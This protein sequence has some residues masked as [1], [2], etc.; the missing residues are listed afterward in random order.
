MTTHQIWSC[1]VPTLFANF[2]KFY[3]YFTFALNFR[4]NRQICGKL[5]QEQKSYKQK[6]KLGMENTP[7]PPVPPPPTAYRAKEILLS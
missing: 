4:K 6:A 7:R 5:A 1:H 2:E 3:F